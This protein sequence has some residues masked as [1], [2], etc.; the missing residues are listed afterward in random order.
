[1]MDAL[2]TSETVVFFKTTW[3]YITED[4][5]HHARCCENLKSHKS[6]KFVFNVNPTEAL[7]VV[8]H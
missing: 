3:C 6:A 4:C 5:Q 1:M 2:C 8:Q 7:I